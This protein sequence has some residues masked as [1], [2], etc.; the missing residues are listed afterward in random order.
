M[1]QLLEYIKMAFEN[2]RANKGR[3]I[4]TMLGIIIGISSVILIISVGNGASA[5]ISDELEGIAGGQVYLYTNNETM[6]YITLDDIE[7]IKS[8]IDHIIG[9]TPQETHSGTILGKKGDYSAN[10]ICGTQ[11]LQYVVNQDIIRGKYFSESDYQNANKV[12]LLQESDAIRLFGTSDVVGM[13]LEI[14]V[15]NYTTDLTIIGVTKSSESSMIMGANEEM[16][17]VLYMPVSIM[18]KLVG[19]GTESYQGIYVVGESGAY[20]KQIANSSM[21]LLE[22]RHHTKENGVYKVEDFNDYMDQINTVL[23]TMTTFVVLVAAISLLVGGIGVMNIMLVSV[24]ERTREIGIRKALGARTGSIMLQFLSE[25]AI[26]TLVGGIIGI[27]L[28]I[29]GANGICAVINMGFKPSI[30]IFTILI[31]TLFSSAVGLFFG[32]Y[33]ARKAAKLSP[34]EALRRN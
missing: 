33:P 24:T 23:G 3:S 8:K 31:A 20:S 7:A 18:N 2:I 19:Y 32:I 30:S 15:Y 5:Q 11:D 4:L 10:F 13:T 14:T 27:S 17:I 25:S 22:A 29:I 1:S 34:I 21:K 12:C 28:G 26:I 16:P 6:D 9:V